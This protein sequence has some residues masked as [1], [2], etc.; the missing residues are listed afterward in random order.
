MNGFCTKKHV[1]KLGGFSGKL[2]GVIKNIICLQSLSSSTDIQ[3][4]V[5]YHMWNSVDQNIPTQWLS[6][7]AQDLVI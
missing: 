7:E 4:D 6:S 1:W 2:I 5:F 3:K